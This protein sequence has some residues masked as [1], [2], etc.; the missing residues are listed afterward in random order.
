MSSVAP[1]RARTMTEGR[2]RTGGCAQGGGRN[3]VG[4]APVREE[5]CPLHVRQTRVCTYLHSDRALV[6]ESEVQ[7]KRASLHIRHIMNTIV[8]PA[9][10]LQ[11]EHSMTT[12]NA[13]DSFREF[14][15]FDTAV[16][17]GSMI[18]GKMQTLNEP[19]HTC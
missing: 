16:R 15:G 2:Y 13:A 9:M 8:H 4:F 3:S 12:V 11:L 6:R 19:A 18:V 17:G 1:E 7:H 14:M 10:R 5:H